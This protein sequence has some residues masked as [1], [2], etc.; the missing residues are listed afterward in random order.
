M[1]PDSP[2]S[3]A[4]QWNL[5]HISSRF[6][7]RQLKFI[8]Q[9]KVLLFWCF[10]ELRNCLLEQL[11]QRSFLLLTVHHF[12]ISSPLVYSLLEAPFLL[13]TSSTLQASQTRNNEHPTLYPISLLYRH[14]AVY[15]IPLKT[16]RFSAIKNFS[17]KISNNRAYQ[18]AY[19]TDFWTVSSDT[20]TTWSLCI[21]NR[22]NNHQT[23]KIRH[24]LGQSDSTQT[25][26][27]VEK[28]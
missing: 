12:F 3:V 27:Y 7:N 6:R 2:V 10:F 8:E 19:I 25:Y 9:K 11:F 24:S 20:D 4:C 18:T 21:R 26:P 13:G 15:R 16:G 22:P 23:S 14:S 1:I 17:I 28:S 5:L